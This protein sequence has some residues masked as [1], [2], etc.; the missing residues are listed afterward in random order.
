M[1]HP[2]PS[3][4][5]VSVGFEPPAF[6]RRVDLDNWNRYAAVNDEFVPI[7][8]DDAAGREA[9]YPTA[10]GMGNLHTAYLHA[11][12]RSWLGGEGRVSRLEIRF[13]R[14]STRGVLNRAAG[15]VTAVD[16]DGSTTT[17]ELS[18][19]VEDDDGEQ[20]TTGSATAVIGRAPPAHGSR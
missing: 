18:I 7:H 19:W 5:E 2:A 16:N 14:P 15:V 11:F 4:G 1:D 8:M 3:L 20:L 9:G 13:R 6:E 17:V 12:L 10:F